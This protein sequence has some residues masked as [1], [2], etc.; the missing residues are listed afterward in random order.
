MG[1]EV[2]LPLSDHIPLTFL[3]MKMSSSHITISRDGAFFLSVYL[4]LIGAQKIR[5]IYMCFPYGSA[6]TESSCNAGDL[7]LISG[8]GRSPGEGKGYPLQ[9]SS[10]ENSMDS[11]WGCKE[12]DKI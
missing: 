4:I 1:T 3:N 5:N 12:S 7:G 6:S 9:Y 10:L 8:L 2:V 11:P